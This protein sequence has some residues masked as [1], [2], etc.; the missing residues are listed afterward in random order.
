MSKLADEFIRNFLIFGN[1]QY[2]V[3]QGEIAF[4]SS[5]RWRLDFG[6]IKQMIAV[7]IDGGQ[8]GVKC[9]KCKGTGFK[10]FGGRATGTCDI[11]HGTGKIAGRHQNT[12]RLQDDFEKHNA[13]TAKG[14]R[15]YH[16]STG[17]IRDKRYYIPLFRALSGLQVKDD[18]LKKP[19]G[20]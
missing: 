18:E 1:N 12:K 5:R 15:V 6:W 20:K 4:A 9:G 17:M 7:E 14:W 8:F 2:P 16:F 13:A 19:E 3:P 10:I 11:C